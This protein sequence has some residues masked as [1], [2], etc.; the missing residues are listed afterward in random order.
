MYESAYR[1]DRH[2][3]PHSLGIPFILYCLIQVQIHADPTYGIFKD[4]ILTKIIFLGSPVCINFFV[5]TF[6]N[7]FLLFWFLTWSDLSIRFT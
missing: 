1:L 2:T 3:T 5:N 6:I 7:N 4:D